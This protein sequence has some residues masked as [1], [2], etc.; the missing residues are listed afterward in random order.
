MHPMRIEGA[1]PNLEQIGYQYSCLQL[2]QSLPV[3]DKRPFRDYRCPFTLGI[4]VNKR[5]IVVDGAAFNKENALLAEHGEASSE[6]SGGE[7]N[8]HSIPSHAENM[9]DVLGGVDWR[10]KRLKDKKTLS[11]Y[12]LASVKA[13]LRTLG[14]YRPKTPYEYNGDIVLPQAAQLALFTRSFQEGNVETFDPTLKGVTVGDLTGAFQ[15]V[16]LVMQK[17]PDLDNLFKIFEFINKKVK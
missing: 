3:I 6:S 17:R 7:S 12:N 5:C 9:E 16:G 8:D 14:E 13:T 15:V 1:C 4:T 10:Q 2:S 11:P